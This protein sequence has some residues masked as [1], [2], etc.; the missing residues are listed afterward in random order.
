[1]NSCL[2]LLQ[3]SSSHPSQAKPK[4]GSKATAIN[5]C[6][7]HLIGGRRRKAR[8]GLCTGPQT[9]LGPCTCQARVLGHRDK[10]QLTR[11]PVDLVRTPA[12][13]LPDGGGHVEHLC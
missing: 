12:T 5:Y 8:T 11:T 2:F 3:L 7:P 4:H 13:H 1:M 6:K 10:E 9:V